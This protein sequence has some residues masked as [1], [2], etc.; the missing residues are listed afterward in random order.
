VNWQTGDYEKR[1]NIQ[2]GIAKDKKIKRTDM[3]QT[4]TKQ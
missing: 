1:H 4:A 2:T 3:K